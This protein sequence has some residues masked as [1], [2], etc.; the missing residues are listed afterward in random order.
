[1]APKT[2]EFEQEH[3]DAILDAIEDG[4]MTIDRQ[5]N[6][7]AFNKSA[8]ALTGYTAAE[9]LGQPCAEICQGSL[10]NER[11]PVTS[12]Y[13]S[14]ETGGEHEMIL[15]TKE[16]DTRVVRLH[17]GLLRNKQGAIIGGIETFKDV[18]DLKEL[19]K[20]LGDRHQF[21]NIIG[22]SAPMQHIYQLIE[23]IRESSVT[24]LIQGETGTGKEVVAEAIHYHSSRAR[25]PFIKV[26]CSALPEQLL[27][28]ELFGH[29]R[30]AFTDAVTD[31]PGRF[32]LADGGTIF[33]DEIGDMP[34][35]LQPKLLRVLEKKEFERVGGIKTLKV[36]L[37]IIA[38]TNRNLLD[39]V[40][41]GEF[42]T[43]LFYRLNVV[44]I[45]L[46][47]LRDHREDIPLLVEHFLIQMQRSHGRED[48]S[49]SPETLRILME[50][51]WSGNVRELQNVLEFATVTCKDKVILP[52][53]LPL[54]LR[55]PQSPQPFAVPNPNPVPV[56]TESVGVTGG[57][58]RSVLL[59]AL[60]ET[61]WNY[62][63]CAQKLGIHRTT[64]WRKVRMLGIDTR[65]R[66]NTIP[67]APPSS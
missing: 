42:R 25:G 49:V 4:V 1:M 66:N 7:R 20:K 55:Q 64:L 59:A 35:S 9:A 43:D 21:V 23:D 45:H 33:L 48:L 32:E 16:G 29:V 61:Q 15:V 52:E 19:E 46:P 22:R 34:Q 62:G 18:T 13:R 63:L 51:P 14:G 57:D 44:P 47:A 50:H 5:L 40:K 56:V 12:G 28:T 26:N 10:C 8:Q 36:D 60:N 65:R 2:P 11:C 54:I 30:G 58:E 37:R 3:L 41:R 24:V 31:K 53:N 39:D 67:E 6:I 38:A 17:T 27:E